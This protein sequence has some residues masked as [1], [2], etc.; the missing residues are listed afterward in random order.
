MRT[1]GCQSTPR[2]EVGWGWGG[3][4]WGK[5]SVRTCAILPAAACRA[6]LPWRLVPLRP[7]DVTYERRSGAPTDGGRGRWGA[8][9]LGGGHRQRT[10]GGVGGRHG[11]R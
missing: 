3:V 6:S 4:G 1:G 7:D 11:C 9:A 5:G 2:G 8:R 10:D